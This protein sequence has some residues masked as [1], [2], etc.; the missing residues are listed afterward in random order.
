MPRD[1]ASLRRTREAIVE[2][3][4]FLCAVN[5]QELANCFCSFLEQL[6]NL[7]T[8]ERLFVRWAY[9]RERVSLHLFNPEPDSP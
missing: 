1:A 2:L 4:N 8:L 3:Q 7:Y 5:D 9:H 6:S